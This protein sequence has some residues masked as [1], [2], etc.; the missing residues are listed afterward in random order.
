MKVKTVWLSKKRIAVLFSVKNT[1]IL[2]L[3]CLFSYAVFLELLELTAY[4]FNEV[5]IAV[6]PK[7]TMKSG[8]MEGFFAEISQ[9]CR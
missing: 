8:L 3:I 9:I 5:S 6:N 7:A 4:A 1:S 2:L